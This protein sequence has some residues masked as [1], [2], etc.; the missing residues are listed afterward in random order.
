MLEVEAIAYFGEE[1]GREP[2]SPYAG[3]LVEDED[4]V[5]SRPGWQY[6]ATPEQVV[7][8]EKEKDKG[9]EKEKEK[10]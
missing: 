6:G 5:P 10:E 3:G 7:A 2:V 8:R 4:A 1:K 9:K